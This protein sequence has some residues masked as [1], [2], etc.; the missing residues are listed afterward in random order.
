M[1]LI[2]TSF[3]L[4]FI[5]V[6]PIQA[7]G[8]RSFVALPLE[9]NGHV[10]R[11]IAE[12]NEE[13]SSNYLKTNYAYGISAK[14]TLLLGLPY[15]LSPSGDNKTGNISALYRHT[16][17]QNDKK[18]STYRLAL[19][20]GGIL[21]TQ[22]E[23]DGSIQAG[24]VATFSQNRHGVDIDFLYRKGLGNDKNTAQYD[25]SWQYRLSPAVYPQW[26]I[27]PEWDMVLEL[28]GRYLESNTITHQL[29]AG[30]QWIDKEWVFEGGVFKDLNNTHNTG[31]M[32]STRTHF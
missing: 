17:I 31:L 3:A 10:L 23:A 20:G 5:F 28:N 13:S 8:L 25:V 4:I 27:S 32:F 24:A 6:R 18:D 29:T 11:V 12:H 30:L 1:K 16:I 9:E 15:R 26:G 22:S 21:P 2:I 19:L 14:Q 7:M